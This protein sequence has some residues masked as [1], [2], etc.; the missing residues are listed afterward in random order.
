[1]GYITSYNGEIK[2]EDEEAIEIITKMVDENK[3]P[4]RD[5]DFN[6]TNG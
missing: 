4:F 3:T 1:M 5:F 2:L 6:I